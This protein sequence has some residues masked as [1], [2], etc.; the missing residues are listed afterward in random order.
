MS[1]WRWLRAFV[2]V[3]LIIC[4]VSIVA[5][6][7]KCEGE[8][9]DCV[10]VSRKDNSRIVLAVVDN[11]MV[12]ADIEWHLFCNDSVE[13]S[14]DI[15][16]KELR[17]GL[18]EGVR[19]VNTTVAESGSHKYSV[20]VGMTVFEYDVKIINASVEDY[21]IEEW[22]SEHMDVHMSTAEW[23]WVQIKVHLITMAFFLLPFPFVFGWVVK[24]KEKGVRQVI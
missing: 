3:V 20:Y 19:I 24:R 13:W 23:L 22:Q 18:M 7:G 12:Y 10:G 14:I 8:V 11:G 5:M 9:A 17:R 1:D 2:V 21:L 6:C 15:D 4:S 16:G